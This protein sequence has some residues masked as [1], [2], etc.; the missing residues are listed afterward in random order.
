MFLTFTFSGSRQKRNA[1]TVRRSGGLS[2]PKRTNPDKKLINE[3][4]DSKR[5]HRA[6]ESVKIGKRP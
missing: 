2:R 5:D 3:T 6:E 4:Q 1:A